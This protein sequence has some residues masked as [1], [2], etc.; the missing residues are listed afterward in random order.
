MLCLPSIK[1]RHPSLAYPFPSG[2]PCSSCSALS[3]SCP[4]R[5]LWFPALPLS[6][7]PCPACQAVVL[8]QRVHLL[9]CTH[10]YCSV[11]L[12]S[13]ALCNIHNR[14]S[15]VHFGSCIGHSSNT[16]VHKSW[17]RCTISDC[18]FS[19][20]ALE[21]PQKTVKE[22]SKD[23]AQLADTIKLLLNM[24]NKLGGKM[25]Q[26]RNMFA[27]LGSAVAHDPGED[28]HRGGLP[29]SGCR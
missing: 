16:V 11:S 24:S 9:D 25:Q 22:F 28:R 7:C 4:C 27:G 5:A 13:V 6:S 14:C 2:L 18:R 12:H 26:N 1:R 19:P 8:H 29:L 10:A 23:A 21:H 15:K 3:L 20:Q 17:G